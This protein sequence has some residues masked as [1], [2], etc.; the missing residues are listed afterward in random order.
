M[1]WVMISIHHARGSMVGFAAGARG[2]I[3]YVDTGLGTKTN[4]HQ[5]LFLIIL[6]LYYILSNAVSYNIIYHHRY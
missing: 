5:M 4:Q 2:E 3:V 6:L 1:F